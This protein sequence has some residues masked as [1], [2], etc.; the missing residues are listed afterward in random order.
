[1]TSAPHA[2]GH[3]GRGR[4]HA[5]AAYD[6]HFGR[7]YAYYARQQLADTTARFGEIVCANLQRHLARNLAHGRKHRQ[8]AVRGLHR[9]SGN[10]VHP[11][12][13]QHPRQVCLCSQVKEAE[14]VQSGP[15]I[16]ILLGQRLLYL[17]HQ[18][19]PLPDLCGA[20]NNLHALRLEAG[21]FMA[22]ALARAGLEQHRVAALD[23]Q[24]AYAGCEPHAILLIHHFLGHPNNHGVSTQ[25]ECA[26]DSILLDG[27]AQRTLQLELGERE[28]IPVRVLEPGHLCAA[29]HAP[30][31]I[32][33]LRKKLVALKDHVLLGETTYSGANVLH[34]PP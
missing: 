15:E 13:Q 20:L 3:A 17:D 29:R 31:T 18:P 8:R 5:A 14:E 19:C 4:A 12:L 10:A 28:Q 6:H 21:V 23:Q 22:G 25:L 9:L 11:L 34:S 30:D 26:A 27:I 1:M 2:Q 32:F 7:R 33:V 16:R 24:A